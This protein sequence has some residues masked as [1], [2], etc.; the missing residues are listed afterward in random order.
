M[1]QMMDDNT[2]LGIA[3]EESEEVGIRLSHRL[4]NSII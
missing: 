1:R 2:S 3:G 4:A